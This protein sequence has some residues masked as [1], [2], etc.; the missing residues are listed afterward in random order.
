MVSMGGFDTHAN[1][2]INHERLMSR[3]SL[4]VNNFYEDLGFQDMQKQSV[5]HDLF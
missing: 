2:P 5:K 1:Q 4:A 3:L